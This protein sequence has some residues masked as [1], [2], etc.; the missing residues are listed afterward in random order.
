MDWTRKVNPVTNALVP[1]ATSTPFSF[2]GTWYDV[3]I[4]KQ[5]V[6]LTIFVNNNQQYQYSGP[7]LLSGGFL[8]FGA[9]GAGA[10]IELDDLK[11]YEV[12]PQLTI[13]TAAV[14]L[15]WPTESNVTYQV[16]WSTDMQAWSNLTSIIGT[17]SDTNIV[18]WI[19]GPKKFYRLTVQ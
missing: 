2:D 15:R 9:F 7:L 14:R 18:E 1:P 8:H 10:T 17:G 12:A 3:R 4:I 16:Q 6:S 19:D 5:G 13:E 11:I